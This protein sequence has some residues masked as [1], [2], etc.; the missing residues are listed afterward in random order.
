ML[1]NLSLLVQ[2]PFL[3]IQLLMDGMLVGSI[4]ALAAYG[5]ALVWGVMNV[6]NIAQG[7][8]VILGGF[9][10]WWLTTHGVNP[11]LG[12]P[13]SFVVLYVVGWIVYKIV[14]CRVVA[15]DLFISILATFG[16]SILL[17]QLMNLM[18]Q[19]LSRLVDYYNM[20]K[21]NFYTELL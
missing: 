9:V 4:F 8:F 5:L 7:E 3:N 2:A 20:K 10:T 11:F 14:I 19:V 13:I 17:Q 18:F 12:I 16:I 6:I 21:K 15:Q 1:D